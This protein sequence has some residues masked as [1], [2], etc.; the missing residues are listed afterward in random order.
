VLPTDRRSTPRLPARLPV[1]LTHY[2]MSV[3]GRTRN[4]SIDGVFIE[5]NIHCE[6][7][8]RIALRVD[9]QKPMELVGV[10]MRVDRT[11]PGVGLRFEWTPDLHRL[12]SVLLEIVEEMEE[13]TADLP[14]DSNSN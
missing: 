1:R 3:V 4:I 11:S 13:R 14:I 5:T 2:G 7:G 12:R 10:V 8:S 6:V 9:S